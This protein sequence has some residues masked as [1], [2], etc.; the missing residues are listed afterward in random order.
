ME[1]TPCVITV[2]V[3]PLS[4]HCSISRQTCNALL[5]SLVPPLF[6]TV[7]SEFLQAI[8]RQSKHCALLTVLW[9]LRLLCWDSSSALGPHLRRLHSSCF[10]TLN[11]LNRPFSTQWCDVLLLWAGS[12][13]TCCAASPSP[14]TSPSTSTRDLTAGTKWSSTAVRMDPGIQRRKF[15]ACPS[16]RARP[17]KWSSSPV[18]RAT[19]SEP[20]GVSLFKVH[21]CFNLFVVLM[22][23][24]KISSMQS[25]VYN[26][27]QLW[28]DCPT[29]S[30]FSMLSF[31]IS[32]CTS[33]H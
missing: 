11:P 5:L 6:K 23:G 31:I 3:E 25:T 28:A 21:A 1:G 24:P 20:P 9:L 10:P 33:F 30:V 17:L 18:P 29:N 19:R 4:L 22:K 7:I 8:S 32:S 26:T 12:S 16:A 14:A 13:S 27:E 2:W 15:A